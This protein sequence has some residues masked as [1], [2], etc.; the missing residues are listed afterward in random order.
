VGTGVAGFSGDGRSATHAEID[1]PSSLAVATNG[2]LYFVQQ[3]RFSSMI[4]EVSP[5]GTIE[6]VVGGHPNCGALGESGRIAADDSVIGDVALAFGPNGNLYMSGHG[7]LGAGPLLELTPQRDIVEAPLSPVIAK[8][9]D[10]G[11]GGLAFAPSGEVYI[12]CESGGGHIKEVLAVAPNGSTTAFPDVYPY[13]DASGF[14]AAPGGSVVAID[15]SSVVRIT[16]GGVRTIIDLGDNRFLGRFDGHNGSMEPNGIAVDAEGN[17]Y[18]ASTPGFGNGTFNGVIE[19]HHHGG[20][21][22]LW[23]R[24]I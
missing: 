9:V 8:A 19:I 11:G 21:Q 7:C 22:V 14:A 20:V 1:D 6:T 24:R 23:S 12:A 15:F 16:P 3:G 10:C 4:R 5:N 17:I 2:T 18:L 13:D